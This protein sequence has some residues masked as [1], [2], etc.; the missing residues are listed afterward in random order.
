MSA[1]I[2]GYPASEDSGMVSTITTGSKIIAAGDPGYFVIV[3]RIGLDLEVTSPLYQ[4]AVMGAGAGFPTGQRGDLRDVAQH[5]P[6]A[7][8]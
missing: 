5:E 6:L 1:D 2:L 4:Q 7:R 8:R 3:D